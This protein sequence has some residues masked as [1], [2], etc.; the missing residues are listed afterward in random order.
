MKFG[1][2]V[3]FFAIIAPGFLIL[4]TSFHFTEEAIAAISTYLGFII[5]HK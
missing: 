3:C 1:T 4:E 2:I 5:I